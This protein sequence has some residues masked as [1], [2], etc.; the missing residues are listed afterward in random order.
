MLYP[1]NEDRIVTTDSVTSH[2]PVYWCRAANE[3][4]RPS[5]VQQTTNIHYYRIVSYPIRI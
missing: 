2:H 4:S 3:T 5:A 1:Q